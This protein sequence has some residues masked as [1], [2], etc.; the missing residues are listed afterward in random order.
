MGLA[1]DVVRWKSAKVARLQR[2]GEKVIGALVVQ[3]M[4]EEL[5][6]LARCTGAANVMVGSNIEVHRMHGIHPFG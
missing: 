2:T 5:S 4:I 6:S 1:Q 3:E